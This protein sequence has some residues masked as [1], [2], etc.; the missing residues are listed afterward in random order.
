MDAIQTLV[1]VLNEALAMDRAA[2]DHLLSTRVPCNSML[3][4]HATVQVWHEA[5]QSAVGVLGLLNGF[6]GRLAPNRVVVAVYEGGTLMRFEV[7]TVVEG[8]VTTMAW[9]LGG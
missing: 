9:R 2:M 8:E 7:G 3:A 4:E 1:D 5:G 6:V